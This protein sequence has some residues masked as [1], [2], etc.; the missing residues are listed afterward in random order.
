[1]CTKS[2]WI[3]S[4]MWVISR[5]RMLHVTQMNMSFHSVFMSHGRHTPLAV[6]PVKEP[7]AMKRI[8][9]TASLHTPELQLE[10]LELNFWSFP[11]Q[12]VGKA[13]GI[14]AHSR[15]GQGICRWVNMQWY[16][17]CIAKSM[18]TSYQWDMSHLKVMPNMYESCH[19][20]MRH[21]KYGWAMSHINEVDEEYC[22]VNVNELHGLTANLHSLSIFRVLL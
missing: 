1:M 5:I 3:M 19:T 20:W 17:R 6:W 18:Q 8:S 9:P 14:V 21:Y 12:L 10:S 22:W 4:H 2:V 11:A 13:Q 16:M 7:I 15:H